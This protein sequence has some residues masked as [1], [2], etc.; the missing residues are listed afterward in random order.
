M[1]TAIC[2]PCFVHWIYCLT[3]ELIPS[4][5]IMTS[6]GPDSVPSSNW[7]KTTVPWSPSLSLDDDNDDALLLLLLLRIW[8]NFFWNCNRHWQLRL[9]EDGGGNVSY[10][11]RC[12]APR[13][14][15]IHNN[16]NGGGDSSS[17]SDVDD[18]DVFGVFWLCMNDWSKASAIFPPAD[19]T[20]S[21]KSNC[22]NIS[23]SSLLLL[24]LLLFH[25]HRHGFAR[26][27]I[28]VCD[29]PAW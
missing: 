6:Y 7:Q 1:G 24:L 8:I 26:D 3:C 27:C 5:P 9:V 15:L 11:T 2:F 10:K 29:I 19:C 25:H 17:G 4:Q 14:I 21:F 18:D 22:N 28:C 13:I 23:E 16:D 12:K 20:T